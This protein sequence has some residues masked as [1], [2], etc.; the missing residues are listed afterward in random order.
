M[1]DVALSP[2]PR[3]A[4]AKSPRNAM[5]RASS[6]LRQSSM[7]YA[8]GPAPVPATLVEEAVRRSLARTAH[9]WPHAGPAGRLRALRSPGRGIAARLLRRRH[10]A[11]AHGPGSGRTLHFAG[12][13][14]R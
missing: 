7:T 5:Q 4:I 10:P 14:S 12:D 9:V 6:I 13:L 2:G 3:P 11:G 8:F 1:I